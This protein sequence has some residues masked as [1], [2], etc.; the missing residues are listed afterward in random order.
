MSGTPESYRGPGANVK[1]GREFVREIELGL[2]K[3][4]SRVSGSVPPSG[5]D[6]DHSAGG[7]S[8][9]QLL[10][11]CPLH[12]LDVF[13]GPGVEIQCRL[14]ISDNDSI[15]YVEGTGPLSVTRSREVERAS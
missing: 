1:G 3:A 12:H 7:P 5:G 2:R 9:L 6:L 10:G 13:D 8:A 14:R 15:H 4:A 11:L